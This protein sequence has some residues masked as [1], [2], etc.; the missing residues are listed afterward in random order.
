M[1]GLQTKLWPSRHENAQSKK[2][3]ISVVFVKVLRIFFDFIVD[4]RTVLRIQRIVERIW[5]H[6]LMRISLKIQ[7]CNIDYRLQRFIFLQRTYY[8]IRRVIWFGKC[9]VKF[10]SIIFTSSYRWI[11]NWQYYKLSFLLTLLK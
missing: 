11:A 2:R 8:N 10:C 3:E 1:P 7:V 6:L 5:N 4:R 9:R